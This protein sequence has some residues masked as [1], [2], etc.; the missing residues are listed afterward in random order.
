[1]NSK[2]E[3]E[4]TVNEYLSLK[5]EGNRTFIY[6]KGKRFRQC[7][8]L[9][10]HIPINEVEKYDRIDS[11]DE[12]LELYYRLTGRL[13]H[14]EDYPLELTPEQEFR[15]HC[16]NIQ[17]WVENDYDTRLLH[18]NLAFPLLE[19]LA[20]EGLERAKQLLKYEIM[21]RFESGS[22]NVLLMLTE[23]KYTYYLDAEA[24]RQKIEDLRNRKL[25][26]ERTIRIL[27]SRL[28][29]HLKKLVRIEQLIKSR[30]ENGLDGTCPECGGILIL[31]RERAEIV[32][33]ECG[34]VVHEKIAREHGMSEEF[35]DY[36]STA[37]I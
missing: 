36:F 16:S 28:R 8:R 2:N 4:F 9:V 22:I 1:M 37:L 14:D 31:T 23:K 18:S 21:K 29:F 6:V 24:I 26:H 5:L 33:T 17:V 15:G 11:I 32:C 19:A 34:L 10:F 12:A 3:N 7:M 20:R 27:I 13:I 30:K 25:V 35:H